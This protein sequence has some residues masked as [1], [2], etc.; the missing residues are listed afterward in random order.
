MDSER[1]EQALENNIVKMV[2]K[3]DAFTIDYK[4]RIDVSKE[5]KEAYKN[6]N[7]ARVYEQ[8]KIK[9]EEELAKKIVNKIVTEMGTDIKKLMCNVD[10]RD[11]FRYFLRKGVE[12]ITGRIRKEGIGE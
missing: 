9:L 2:T 6:I 10:I 1:I 8:V 4:N 12:E 11:D 3:G 7:Y 5:L